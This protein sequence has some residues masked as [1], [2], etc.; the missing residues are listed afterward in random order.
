MQPKPIVDIESLTVTAPA[1]WAF[2]SGTL[3]ER[4]CADRAE[5]REAIAEYRAYG[6]PCVDA[7]CD[8]CS[9]V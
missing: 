4:V 9:D 8:W 2:Q 6:E 5:V 3:H 7:K 1:G